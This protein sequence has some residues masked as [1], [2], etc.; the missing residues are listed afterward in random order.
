VVSLEAP[1]RAV[2]MLRAMP[3][4]KWNTG[5]TAIAIGNSLQPGWLR[6]AS[7]VVQLE[8]ELGARVVLEGPAE[9]QL[10]SS[11]EGY[12]KSGKLRAFVPEPAQGF[13][14]S[15]PD[16]LVVDYGTE[17]GFSVGDTGRSEVHVFKGKVEVHPSRDQS[18]KQMLTDHMAVQLPT[19]GPLIAMAANSDAFINEAEVGR[20]RREQATQGLERWRNSSEWLRKHRDTALYFDFQSNDDWSR[21]LVNQAEHGSRA[22]EASIV[23]CDWVSGRWAG[24]NALEFKRPGD[25][26]RLS[27]P[28][29]FTDF[30]MLAWLRIDS[31]PWLQN[32]LI[33]GDSFQPGEMHWFLGRD[34]RLSIGVRNQRNLWMNFKSEPAIT[35]ESR[36]SW[37]MLATVY[38]GQEVDGSVTVSSY[39]NGRLLG[40]QVA[41][42]PH[43]N[44]ELGTFEIGNWAVRPDEP[45]WQQRGYQSR[46]PNDHVRSLKGRI[47]EL[48]VLRGLLRAEDIQMLWEAGRPE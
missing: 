43:Q 24:K 4:V 18:L 34:G 45:H 28:G 9:F 6:L 16:C 46:H 32:S 10:V 26:V 2:A 29:E 11:N 27:V 17:F 40:E 1:S 41:T 21:T 5:S 35:P 13:R 48:A 39:V 37:V 44:V 19:T 8:F 25:R 42:G 22:I 38:H 14:I 31:L 33:M 15:S 7:G 47:D 23:G 12:L 36:G 20:R 30:T 3:D